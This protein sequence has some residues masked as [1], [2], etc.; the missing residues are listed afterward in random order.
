MPLPT[1]AKLRALTAWAKTKLFWTH[2]RG[3]VY[4]L[5]RNQPTASISAFIDILMEYFKVD[6]MN[7]I[8]KRK[9]TNRGTP[10]FQ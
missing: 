10:I 8:D 2:G 9:W 7:D 5:Q 6:N 3:A 4:R 1:K